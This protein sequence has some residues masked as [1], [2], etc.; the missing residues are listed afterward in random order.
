MKENTA[1][2]HAQV[3]VDVATFLLNEKRAD[4]HAVESRMKVGIVLIPNVHLETPNYTISRLRHEELNRSE[5]LQP[6]Y[7]MVEKPS[8]EGES[9]KPAQEAAKARPQAAVQGITPTQPA[10]VREAE[11][12]PGIFGKLFGWLKN[13]GE[14][15]KEEP[16]PKA[17]REQPRREQGNRPRRD[18]NDRGERGGQRSGQRGEGRNQEPRGEQAAQ[19]QPRPPRPA[20][21]EQAAVTAA[22]ARPEA[23]Q[24]GVGEAGE[25]QRAKRGRRGGRRERGERKPRE[26]QTQQAVS[27]ESPVEQTRPVESAPQLEAPKPMPVHEEIKPTPVVAAEPAPAFEA[28]KAAEA[29][30][31]AAPAPVLAPVEPL[32]ERVTTKAKAVGPELVQIETK[33]SAAPVESA[34][35]AENK[36]RPQRR[37]RSAASE[38]AAPAE[39]VQIETSADKVK[40]TGELQSGEIVVPSAPRENPQRPH[41]PPPEAEPL[42]Q[43][44][45]GNK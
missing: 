20:P 34:I 2:I 43:I 38:P 29:A 25:Q 4:I 9:Q 31:V 6:S 45:T 15:K 11:S 28:P 8:E 16:Q 18:R 30:P 14:E 12:K 5:P 26:A 37:R 17:R 41:M 22:V 33:S 19:K 7:R 27:T 39:L 42:V 36:P 10:P 24:E 13:I 23:A 35:E 44:E 3:P 32:I 21:A 1:S 40:L